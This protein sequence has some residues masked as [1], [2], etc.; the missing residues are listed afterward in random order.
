M[1]QPTN[2]LSTRQ[3]RLNEVIANYLT[4]LG[5]GRIP[6]RAD[7]LAAHPDLAADLMAFFTD[8]DQVEQIAEPMR[9]FVP[10]NA[11]GSPPTAADL[12]TLGPGDTPPPLV[13]L[14]PGRTFGDYQ[15]LEE[16]ARGGMGVVYKARQLSLNRM[17]ALKMILAG[18]LASPADVKR[19]QTEA[20]AAANLDHPHIVPI[21]EVGV[22]EGLHYFSMKLVEGGSLAQLPGLRGQESGVSKERERWAAG[23]IA[24]V[25]RAVH[26][27]HQQRILHRDL[28]PANILLD[29]GGE[30]H[31]TDFGLAKRVEGDSKLTQ[32]G[33]IVG[34]PSYMAPEQA[35]G[36]K[37]VGT[38]AD[39]YGLGAIF[40]EVLTG[41]PPFRA[42][43]PLD[44][45]FQVLHEEPPRP[46]SLIPRVDR[47]L[48]TICL[49]CLD[50][51]PGRRYGSAEAMAE[52]LE[53][54]LAGEPIQ[55]RRSGVAE[56]TVKWAK[57]RP[58]VAGLT[59]LVLL[60]ATLGTGGVL[61]NWQEALAA[62][63]NA[64]TRAENERQAKEQERAA[65]QREEIAKIAAQQAEKRE[66]E[67]RKAAVADRD[68]KAR[69]LDRAEG[70]RISAEASAARHLDPGLSLLLAS[71]GV[72]R[73]PNHLTYNVLYDALQ[74]LRE[75]RTIPAN[76]ESTTW[77]QFAAAGK[78]VVSLG[79]GQTSWAGT[80][81]HAAGRVWDA[82]TGKERAAWSG[83]SVPVGAADLSPDGTRMAVTIVGH[84][85]IQYQD[86]K[87]PTKHIFTDRVVYVWDTAT[88]KDVLHLRGH[89]DRVV[90]VRFS[91]DGKRIV[92]AS[93]DKTARIWDAQTGKE[94]HVLTGHQCS[95]RS[96]LFSRDGKRVLTLS[97]ARNDQSFTYPPEESGDPRQPIV[98]PGPQ[99]R[100]GRLA[101]SGYS[102][103]G[104]STFGETKLAIV[105][106]A[107]TGKP[108]TILTKR[109]PNLLQFGH[110]WHPQAAA[111]SPD[112]KQVAIAFAENDAALWDSVKGGNETQV[113]KGHE[114]A[115]QGIAFSPDSNKVATA[116]ADHTIRIWDTTAGKELLRL[117]GHQ[118][119][120]TSIT[121]NAEGKWVLSTSDDKTARVWDV[122]T[123][124][125]RA[126]FKGHGGAVLSAAFSP[127]GRHVVTA[128][129]MTVRIWSLVHDEPSLFLSGHNGALTALD[130]SPD[131]RSLLTAGPDGTVRL[132]ETGSGKERLVLGRGKNL[133]EIRAAQFSADGKRVVTAS[134]NTRV[135]VNDQLVNASAVHVWD[136]ATGADLLALVGHAEGALAARLSPDG[137]LL[138]TISDGQVRRI[139][140]IVSVNMPQGGISGLKDLNKLMTQG[141]PGNYG[142]VRIWEAASGKLL[143]TLP[144]SVRQRFAPSFS[145]DGQR[146]LMMFDNDSTVYLLD[147][148]T[149]KTLARLRGHQQAW[150]DYL[151][152]FSPDGR[153]VVTGTGDEVMVWDGATG[154][155]LATFR[156]FGQSISLAAFS[157]HAHRLVTL[158][159][160]AG[161]IW[162]TE[163]RE[164]LA[165]LKDHEKGVTA[166][167]FSA[168]GKQLVTGAADRTAIL[169]ATETG[170]MLGYYRGHTGAVSQVAINPKLTQVA[171]ASADGTARLWPAD[172]L[173]GV[174]RRRTRELT[175]AERDRYEVQLAANGTGPAAPAVAAPVHLPTALPPP[176]AALP[177]PLLPPT[178]PLPEAIRTQVQ[179]QLK[180]LSDMVKGAKTDLPEVRK[181]L[182][183][184]QQSH[185]GTPEALAA[186][187]LL[188]QLPSPYDAL[189]PARIP[190]E[191]RLPGQPRELVAVLGELRQRHSGG[192]NRLAVSRDAKLIATG[193][194]DDLIHIW[195]ADTL[196]QRWT[197]RGSLA[198]F[199]PDGQS[200]VTL[201]DSMVHI[202]DLTGAEPRERAAGKTGD[203]QLGAL[204]PEGNLLTCLG[205]WGRIMLHWDL[206]SGV[207]R[208]IGIQGL[209]GEGQRVALATG[210]QFLA[211]AYQDGRVQLWRRIGGELKEWEVLAGNYQWGTFLVFGADGRIL[212][213]RGKT[214]GVRVWDLTGAKP[215]EQAV[216]LANAYPHGVEMVAF[217]ADGKLLVSSGWVGHGPSHVVKLWDIISGE[218]VERGS[219]SGLTDGVSQ[220]A[221]TPDSK[222]LITGGGCTVRF[223]DLTGSTPQER[224]TLHGHTNEVRAVAFAPDRP[225]LASSSADGTLRFWVLAGGRVQEVSA[226]EGGA[227]HLAFTRDG[228]TLIAGT[229]FSA[230]IW[231][232]SA[233]N[234]RLKAQLPVHSHGPVGMACSA[235]GKWLATGSFGPILRFWDLRGDRPQQRTEIPN[236]PQGALG[237]STL[238]FSPDGRLLVAGRTTGDC[239]LRFWRVSETGLQELS[240][241][242]MPGDHVAF[243]PDGKNLAYGS[244]WPRS[245]RILDLTTPY[246]SEGEMFRESEQVRC[247]T[248]SPDGTYL[249]T[250]GWSGEVG[251]WRVADGEKVH[252]WKMPGSVEVVAFAED[253]R[254][255]AVGNA[256]GTIYILRLGGSPKK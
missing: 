67:A 44:T 209:A 29:A 147:P 233:G 232:L 49:K 18:S 141:G 187:R 132:W 35:A 7:L 98:D 139:G 202:W 82:V 237:V 68:A 80:P 175:Q 213:T 77:A 36:K 253:G 40:Y 220:L 64:E 227:G 73:V 99:N 127:G 122:E 10:A 61:W 20:E 53:R 113:L 246:P 149:G 52:D 161:Y 205:E 231:D 46:R 95:I 89:K 166:A 5:E 216:W 3:Q 138:F 133:G 234:P 6:N 91:P 15:L 19:F 70:L 165:V 153:R 94:Q 50:K 173:G 195:E 155:R 249:V 189:D 45:L 60:S 212:A 23:L 156:G 134:T 11:A 75:Q 224:T 83:F 17:V 169:W 148:T 51:E 170:K 160:N 137:R 250:G 241:A 238:A 108:I 183:A 55:A 230:H 107:D 71:E 27:A 32:S 25:A 66:E 254:H 102:T 93:W 26:F 124:E 39:V 105:W 235:D 31:V 114:G 184:I 222:L 186:I 159:G 131:G 86:G 185:P 118:D 226:R 248:F 219:I 126:V 163:T 47:D 16:L 81:D 208:R 62:K 244:E 162:N 151:G 59:G 43:S 239:R 157:P 79:R 104:S 54:W 177:E 142:L 123:G 154:Q 88:G 198:G 130:F 206:G 30:P 119:P 136:T 92:T 121:F 214:P 1:S 174:S 42:H 188:M 197:L 13:P 65:R 120:V 144:R 172:L 256:N 34:T 255:L 228:R 38:A 76:D 146:L 152:A 225:W 229:T 85:T 200:L 96:V 180:R 176:G 74:D 90:S 22:H 196:R 190:P 242:R 4:A 182:L 87:L 125:Q 21:F 191:D 101:Q 181:E 128:G 115:V 221:L 178:P 252:S 247:L 251:V 203:V 211:R 8:H 63:R 194:A 111:F 109:R 218:P 243:S 168:D 140:G 117:R 135:T 215:K 2:E 14:G 164:L 116:G 78:L 145:R 41:H 199:G 143:T 167:A 150:G 240:V 48:E 58:A 72:Q 171:T 129:D 106:A 97:S 9:P 84:Q 223:W 179:A 103:G 69:A 110:V 193:G 158:S 217:S 192:V 112:G 56:R 28:K 201:A 204:S 24:K 37:T 236:D 33:V 57:R 210:G 207:P 245:I 12:P 100:A